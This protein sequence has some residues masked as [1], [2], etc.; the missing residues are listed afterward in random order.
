[1]AERRPTLKLDKRTARAI[2]GGH[3]WIYG[4]AIK[5]ARLRL[6]AGDEVDVV[7]SVGSPLG[8][9]LSDGPDVVASGGPAVRMISRDS[10]AP[11]LRKLIF[12]RVAAARRLRE[13]ILPPNTTGFRLLHG[14]ADGLPGLVV[15]RYG[16]VVVIRPDGDLWRRHMQVIVE[17]LRSE[18]GKGIKHGLLRRRQ[19]PTE[20]VFGPPEVPESL[21][22]Q[23]A[24]R[25]YWVRPGHG[26]KTGFFLDQRPNRSHV[27][28]IARAGDRVLNL[29]SF[30]GGFSVAAALGGATTVVSADRSPSI[31][32]DC[33]EQF[34]L[35]E[36]DPEPHAFVSTDLFRGFGSEIT[37]LGPFDIVICDPPALSRKKA[38][39]PNARQAYRRLHEQIA[40]LLAKDGLLVT[41]SCTARLTAEDL[42]DDA[43]AGLER[44]GR[45]IR[46]ELRQAGA[47]PDHPVLPGFPQGRYL[48]CL[49]LAVGT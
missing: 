33:R 5:A 39:L 14:E 22:I 11:E 44:G 10:R 34:P 38:D 32:A 40:P 28:E 36:L 24:G 17:A 2:A 47:G 46:N 37:D 6:S 12:R 3:P 19:D 7:D 23:E 16:P 26:Q 20:T 4:D 15:D 42:L 8:R 13:R 29:F 30:T 35:N 31:L 49:T 41:A 25:S 9:G 21:V 1:M 43:R 48:S 18:G 45:T 27:Q